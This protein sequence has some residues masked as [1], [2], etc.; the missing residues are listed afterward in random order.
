MIRFKNGHVY[1]EKEFLGP[2]FKRTFPL[3]E[4]MNPPSYNDFGV[5]LIYTKDYKQAKSIFLDL[6]KK[7][8]ADKALLYST[9]ANLGTLYE[10]TGKN[11]SA[12]YWIKEAVA[13]DSTSHN[14]SE[15]VHI[16]LLEAKIKAQNNKNRDF[17]KG[18]NI[19]GLDWG[20]GDLPVNV[21]NINI[22]EV[23]GDIFYQ[24]N[25]RLKFIK[26]KDPIM[27]RLL[28][29]MGTAA[30]FV[31]NIQSALEIYDKAEEFG[32]DSKQMKKWKSY[33]N[34]LEPTSKLAYSAPKE[35]KDSTVT[36]YPDEI[37][38]NPEKSPRPFLSYVYWGA[39]I[40]AVIGA[41]IYK[42]AKRK[43]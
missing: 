32:Y 4:N 23:K 10:L 24:L 35:V 31:D 21:G 43:S 20:T 41:I 3:I 28:F 27:A 29:D 19:L 17:L 9:R 36:K 37:F 14:G 7:N 33:F 6:I 5:Y 8:Y 15:W 42:I 38:S 39:V 34:T 16:K 40:G 12:L 2:D 22:S 11:D 25:E 13:I 26:P 1:F 30:A 18:Y